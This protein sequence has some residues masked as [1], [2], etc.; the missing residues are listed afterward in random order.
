MKEY[1]GKKFTI[2]HK[3]TFDVDGYKGPVNLWLSF[4]VRRYVGEVYRYDKVVLLDYDANNFYCK[5][6][7]DKIN[8]GWTLCDWLSELPQE[9]KSMRN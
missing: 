8:I 4:E 7:K 9:F 3:K 2:D 6:E 1:V 5:V